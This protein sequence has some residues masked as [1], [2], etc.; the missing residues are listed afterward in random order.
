MNL[1]EN[2]SNFFLLGFWETLWF[3]FLF[4]LGI[5]E[6][7][8]VGTDHLSSF[9]AGSIFQEGFY[10]KVAEKLLRGYFR[11][12]ILKTVKRLPLSINDP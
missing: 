8:F 10:L 1:N 6:R 12:E 4:Y 3:G 2:F 7:V 5:I 11:M 9:F